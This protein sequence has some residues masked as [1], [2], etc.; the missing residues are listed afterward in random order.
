MAQDKQLRTIERFGSEE[1]LKDYLVED[2]LKKYSTQFGQEL[3]PWPLATTGAFTNVEVSGNQAT[4][5]TSAETL[6][7]STTASTDTFSDTNTQEAGVD[8]ADLVETD[9]E[10]IYKVGD[11]SLKIFDARNSDQLSVASETDLT[12]L[13]NIHGAYLYGDQLTVIS[14]A[15]PW[16][17]SSSGFF[18]YYDPIPYNPTVNVTML[19]VSDPTSVQLEEKSQL[20][21]NLLSSRA[22]G[23]EVYV[24]TRNSF[25]LP[26]P[27]LKSKK[28]DTPIEPVP[29]DLSQEVDL[30]QDVVISK[31]LVVSD[32]SSV[33]SRYETEEE[34]LA[35][36][37]GQE[38]NL[39][40]PNYTTVDHKGKIL[41]EGLLSEAKNIY[42]PLD[43]KKPFNLA[44][45]SVFD[46]D[47]SQPGPKSSTGIPI[48]GLAETYMSLDNLYLLGNNWWQSGETS[49]LKVGLKPLGLVAVGEVPG[50]VLDQF[51]VDEQDDYLRVAA[52]SGSGWNVQNKV[53]VLKQ[54]GQN[55]EIVGSS[56]HL[57]LP[58]ETI[59]S[60]R[61]KDER[62]FVVTFRQ[63][64]PFYTLDL[65]NPTKPQVAGEVKLP[66]FSAY[67]QVIENGDQTQVLGIGRQGSDL[68]VSLF[69]VTDLQ[70]PKEV[71]SYKFPGKYS[72]SEAQWDHHAVGYFPASDTLA[73]PFQGSRGQGLR[74]FDVDPKYGFEVRGDIEH[75]GGSIRR[76]LRI[77]DN[78]YA[79]SNERVT[80]HD[81]ETL[82]LVDEVVWS[83]SDGKGAPVPF[84]DPFLSTVAST[85]P[86]T[87]TDAFTTSI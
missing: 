66:G 38:L 14:T 44:S 23:G 55:L 70:A 87:F 40:L 78:L 19:D 60:A 42:K 65:S 9:G 3:F 45:V 57:G 58:G 62:G 82:K 77:G 4:A 52:T 35:R 74:V 64:D 28:Q 49:F 72:S 13:G 30:S 41:S 6:S 5:E 32:F 68:K 12:N 50:R 73:V 79:I 37:E 34:Y 86:L 7:Q 20:D 61:F 46:L 83:G 69:D 36:I 39:G 84:S 47:D 75:K 51:S 43:D 11:G 81:L 27:Q 26:G 29:V 10:Y 56:E 76:S 8:E 17:F 59:H 54:Q 67:L 80:V 2:A 31:D 24:V 33:S 63:T 1:E 53:H 15:S 21:G 85:E 16:Y 25:G 48:D 22:I 71:D 18:P